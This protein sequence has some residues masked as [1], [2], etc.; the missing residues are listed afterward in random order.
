RLPLRC[1]PTWGRQLRGGSVGARRY[2]RGVPGTAAV[3]TTHPLMHDKEHQLSC[4]FL[5]GPRPTLVEPGPESC[6]DRV[7]NALEEKG[8]GPD[9]LANLVVTH[10]HLAHG[11]G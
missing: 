5:P 2:F 10:V 11:G 4:Y 1:R 6:L 3:Q 7:I 9:D 8:V